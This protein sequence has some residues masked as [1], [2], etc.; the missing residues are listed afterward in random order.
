MCRRE[1]KQIIL[2]ST[3]TYSA[4]TLSTTM[5]TC[6]KLALL[7]AV[8]LVIMACDV[9]HAARQLLDDYDNCHNGWC[10]IALTALVPSARMPS[11]SALCRQH[12]NERAT[13]LVGTYPCRESSTCRL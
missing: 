5:L 10:A 3:S 6:L 12:T 2:G 1:C 9:V 7:F 11:Y 8:M 4:L 13:G